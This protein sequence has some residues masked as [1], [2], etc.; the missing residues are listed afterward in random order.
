[1]WDRAFYLF[2]LL[3]LFWFRFEFLKQQLDRTAQRSKDQIQ[4]VTFQNSQ[5]IWLFTT[6]VSNQ[7]VGFLFEIREAFFDRFLMGLSFKLELTRTQNNST[8]YYTFVKYPG[9]YGHRYWPDYITTTPDSLFFLVYH[10]P[11]RISRSIRLSV[12]PQRLVKIDD[13]AV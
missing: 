6:T 2:A 10:K 9:L 11:G 3:I 5:V 8:N 13:E 12:L 7:F 1:M 4:Q